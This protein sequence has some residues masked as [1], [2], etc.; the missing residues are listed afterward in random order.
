MRLFSHFSFDTLSNSYLIGP[1]GGGDAVLFDP[2]S[3]DVALLDLVEAQRY[4]IRNVILTHCDEA[5]IHG[6]RTLRRVYD[7]AVHAARPIVLGQPASTVADGA[8]IDVGFET[9]RAIALTG[10]S[11]DSIAYCVGGFVF[12]GSA[13]SA[14]EPGPVPNAYAKALLLVDI[15][16]RLLSL[17][18]ETVVLPFFGPPSTIGL[19]RRALPKID[20][21]RIAELP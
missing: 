8:E 17:P 12:T 11:G 5:H 15:Q 21:T 3:F 16:E 9:V 4:Y 10:H 18:D 7:C 20:P 14:A 13:M 19:E 1:E 2:A 6:L